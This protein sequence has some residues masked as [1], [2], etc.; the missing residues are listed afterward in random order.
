MTYHAENAK[1]F[2]K[3]VMAAILDWKICEREISGCFG[4]VVIIKS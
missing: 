1:K 2:V 4:S 3:K